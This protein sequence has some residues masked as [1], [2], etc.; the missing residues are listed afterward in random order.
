M[1]L[2]R[3]PFN[4]EHTLKLDN[5]P[6]I[7]TFYDEFGRPIYIGRTAGNGGKYGLKHR[8]TSYHQK[9]SF[10]EHPTKKALRP[11]IAYFSAVVVDDKKTRRA[12]EK[13]L[14]KGMKHNHY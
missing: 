7:Y 1:N 3:K 4:R 14:K 6:G 5:K 11:E 13:E 10:V 2:N 9:D 8:V 12:M